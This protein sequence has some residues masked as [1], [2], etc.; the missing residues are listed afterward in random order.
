MQVGGQPFVN[1]L[2]GGLLSHYSSKAASLLSGRLGG[3][4]IVSLLADEMLHSDT[5]LRSRAVLAERERHD[6]WSQRILTSCPCP[7]LPARRAP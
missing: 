1:R 6:S 4:T 2:K 7:A 5:D 3:P